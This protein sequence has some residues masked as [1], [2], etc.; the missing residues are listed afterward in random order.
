MSFLDKVT[1]A[2]GD[3]VDRGKKDLDQFMRIQKVNG[4]ISAIETKVAELKGQVQ[5][6]KQ[7]AGEK[8]IDLMK[9]G[10]LSNPDLLV[11]VERLTAIDER[12]AAEQAAIAAKRA[13]IEKI[14]AEAA[15]EHA[16]QSQMATT[17]AV[18]PAAPVVPPPLPVPPEAA[19]A[20]AASSVPPLPEAAKACPQCGQPVANG[21][22]CTE[23]GAKLG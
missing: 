8:A 12:I 18:P 10:T 13:D 5:Q 1:K 4:E 21:A 16:A 3:V 23:C 14:K 6:A 15:A 11:F 9:A 2:V 22:F 20:P 19:P 7:E 17:P